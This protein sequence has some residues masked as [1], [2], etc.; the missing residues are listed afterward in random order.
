MKDQILQRIAA[1][2]LNHILDIEDFKNIEWIWVNREIFKDILY[3]LKIDEALGEMAVEKFLNEIEDKE[4]I[5]ALLSPFQDKDYLP[6]NQYQFSNLEKGYKPTEDIETIIFVKNK[7]Y[8][9]L[10]IQ[11]ISQYGWILKAMAIDTYFKIGLE[12]KSLKETYEDLY[13]EN[14]RIL[15]EILSKREYHFITGVW[16]FRS[17]SKELSFYKQGEFYNSWSEGQADAT[18]NEYIEV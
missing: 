16:K 13:Q 9:K 2:S 3:N 1:A 8:K 5:K 4:M 6:I 10:S 18:F 11:Q 7:Y 15:E 17:E 12:Y 14:D